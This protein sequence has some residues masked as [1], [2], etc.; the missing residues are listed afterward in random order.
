AVSKGE[1]IATIY[2]NENI[3]ENMLTNFRKNVKIDKESVKTKE[4]IEI[5][6]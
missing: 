4:I 3:S 2:A 1:Q 6:S 5:I